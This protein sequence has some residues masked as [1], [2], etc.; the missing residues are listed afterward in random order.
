[1][2]K[3]VSREQI[4]ALFV[5]GRNAQALC[6]T[7]LEADSTSRLIP[8]R[9]RPR[10]ISMALTK[11]GDWATEL[12]SQYPLGDIRSVAEEM[13]VKVEISDQ[14]DEIGNMVIR[15]EYYAEPPRIVIFEQP[16]K[17]IYDLMERVGLSNLLGSDLLIP[18]HVLHELFHHLESLRK[19]RL[20]ECYSV[21]TFGLGPLRLKSSVRVLTEI[22][23]HAFAQ[24]WL[25]L[26]WYPFVIDQIERL[27]MEDALSPV[28]QWNEMMNKRGLSRTISRFFS[29]KDETRKD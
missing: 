18:I 17:V 25:N 29:R 6:E 19:D 15:G 3:E 10:L 13:G 2:T 16:I 8:S 7:I 4:A 27:R 12:R 22:G 11:G 21:T 14:K 26:D 1:L 24:R 28:E 20:S 23:A 5:Q 9:E